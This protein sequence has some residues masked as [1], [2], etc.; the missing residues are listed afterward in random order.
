V[1]NSQPNAENS[2]PLAGVRIVDLTS[3]FM[4]PLATQQLADLG[5]DVLKIESPTGDSI[6]TI[7]PN[8]DIGLGPLYM[9]LNR[10][11]RSVCLDLKSKGGREALL[12]LISDAD[13]LVYNVRPA[14]MERLDLGYETLAALNPSLIYVGMLGFSQKGPYAPLAAYDD[15]I[16]GASGF[17]DTFARTP[18]GVPRY[19]PT[20][21]ADRAA[22]LYAFGVISAALFA[23]TKT[24]KGQ[25]IDIPMFEVMA[26]QVMSDHLYGES[27]IPAQGPMGYPRL[28]VAER[29]PYQTKDGHICCT[30]YTDGQWRAFLELCGFTGMF[31]SDPRFKDM[32]QRTKYV[33]ELYTMVSDELRKRS[34]ADWLVALQKADIPC[35]RVHTLESLLQD[36]HLV[37]TGFFLESDHPDVGRIRHMRSPAEWSD[38]P[39]SVRM[40]APRL[41]QHTREALR[42][43]G[44]SANEI[45]GLIAGRAAS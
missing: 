40:L 26:G 43:A 18:E 4:G 9:H 15:L 5:A 36:P 35:F 19:A 24:G 31:E 2:G 11:K 29:R 16:Q 25:R 32:G 41:G 42:E 10:N 28:L 3:V 6:R 12:R 34:S 7:G 8:G 23:R 22:G 44:Y 20:A 13:V 37:E 30:V 45:D 1:T 38:T 33:V 14:A 39:G 21:V 17:A 27:Y